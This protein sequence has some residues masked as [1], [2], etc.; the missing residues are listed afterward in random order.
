MHV[1]AKENETPPA[2]PA[3]L[4]LKVHWVARS[5]LVPY[6]NNARR[7]GAAQVAK[8]AD[9][10]RRFG[11][12]NPILIDAESRVVAGHGRLKA[13]Q[14]LGLEQ[15]PAIRLDHLSEAELKAY[16]IA[17]NRLAELAEWDEATLAV[18]FEHLIELDPEFD[19]AITGYEF[20][21]IDALIQGKDGP[22][23]PDRAGE[24]PAQEGP[25]VS[26][27]GDLWQLGPHRLLCGDVRDPEALKRLMGE[28]RADLVFTDPPYNLRID[29][30]VCGTG[31]IRHREFAMASGEMTEEEFAGF[32]K[33]TLGNLARASR[34]GAVHF[35]CMDWR[36]LGEMLEAGNAVYGGLINLCVWVKDN[37][38]MGSLY[39]SRH[40]LVLVFRVGAEPH[41]NDVQLGRHGRYRTN[42]WEYPGVN[43]FRK[44]RMD[45]LASHPTV[46]PVALVADAILDCS[47]RG[48][49]VLD[50]FAG[51]GT[52]ILAA[53]RTG[54]VARALEIEPRYVDVAVRR[55]QAMTGKKAIHAE[56]GEAFDDRAAGRLAA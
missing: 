49:A 39:R 28:G 52:T 25:V 26:R 37:G 51:S 5:G 1:N 44:G 48:G 3:G 40:E 45:D 15:V 56:T 8:I 13:A 20:P 27:A 10:I 50:G 38:G 53:E 42:V 6:L 33:E 11:F 36:H 22:S 43:T 4:S 30:N 19:L 21:R 24:L 41:L 29:R 35:V 17:D 9:S 34:P 32:L 54:R 18:E 2:L 14:A 7:H 46:K 23:T 12:I 47:K 16:R 55:W 31:S